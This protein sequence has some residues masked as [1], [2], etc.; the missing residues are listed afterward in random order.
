MPRLARPAQ[1]ERV[2]YFRKL[3]L[4]RLT[5]LLLAIFCLFSMFGFLIDLFGYARKPTPV[6]LAWTLFTGAMAVLY[7]I[8]LARAHR[9][10]LVAAGV[11]LLGSWLIS[12]LMHFFS[13]QL[14]NPSLEQ[15]VHRAAIAI[16][17][18]STSACGLFLRFILKEGRRSVRLETELSFAHGIQTTLVPIIENRSPRW[19]VY[20][21][22]LPSEKVGGDL[23]DAVVLEDGSLFAYVADI[24]GHGLPAGVLMGMVKAAVRTQLF[25]NSDPAALFDRI[26]LV[27]PAVKEPNMYATC[28][29]IRISRDGRVIEYALAGHPP[30]LLAR[31]G[32]NRIEHLIDEQFPLGLLPAPR[33]NSHTLTPSAG[34]LLLIATDGI[35]EAESKHGDEFGLERLDELLRGNVCRPLPGLSAEIHSAVRAFAEQSDDQTLLLIRI[36]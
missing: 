31:P 22:S 30:I 29:A 27:L 16:L 21:I 19:E 6:V 28:A 7:F 5:S 2:L 20:G 11:H 25:A 23:V 18:L 34:D 13:A 24:S 1:R 8:A 15:G 33:W 9:L 32:H 17:I 35:I 4:R 10:V 26:N 3:P 36:L 12:S 14:V